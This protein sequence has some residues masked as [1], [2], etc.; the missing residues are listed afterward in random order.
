MKYPSPN[1]RRL[2]H[3]LVSV[4]VLLASQ[5]ALKAITI[6]ID[7][8]HDD[9]NFF[10][11]SGSTQR[12][13]IEAA[14]SYVGSLILDDLDAIEPDVA[15]FGGAG[16]QWEVSFD[17][18][19]NSTGTLFEDFLT[20][21]ADTIIVFA[22][23]ANLSGA[24][25][26][27]AGFG[28]AEFIGTPAFGTTVGTRGEIGPAADEFSTWG[29]FLSVDTSGP[30][31]DYS[32]DNSTLGV[33]ETHFYSLMLH[34]LGHVVG[35]GTAPSWMNRISA[36]TFTGTEASALYGS[37]V[38][39]FEGDHYANSVTS[40]IFGSSNSQTAALVANLPPNETRFFTE[41]DVAALDDIG[42]DVVSA[43]IPEPSSITLLALSAASLLRRRR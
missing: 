23:G 27:Q 28:S 32:L 15:Y 8:S 41:I 11:S 20:V 19:A 36:S 7:Y 31:W 9:N 10:G 26:A 37:A 3:I 21:P 16:N 4:G 18:P 22:G 38:P 30:I 29:G 42:W 6:Q 17:D 2:L 25:L 34:E 43:P 1:P 24:T 39:T 5:F 13:V 33:G 14:A 40:D 35:L 12:T